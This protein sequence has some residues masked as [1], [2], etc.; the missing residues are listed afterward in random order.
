M[1]P[2]GDED[3]CASAGLKS[4]GPCDLNAASVNFQCE[5]RYAAEVASTFVSVGPI[6]QYCTE[7]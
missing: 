1:V 3:T 2:Q 6:A 4:C 5:P 7:D